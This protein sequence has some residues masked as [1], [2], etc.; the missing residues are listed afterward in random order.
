MVA[1]GDKGVAPSNSRGGLGF[2]ALVDIQGVLYTKRTDSPASRVL[3]DPI[4]LIS[5]QRLSLLGPLPASGNRASTRDPC[6]G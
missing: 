3:S 6:W 5:E 2:R 1:Q 4:F